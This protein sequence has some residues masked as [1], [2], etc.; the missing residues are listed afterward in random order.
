M[1]A[2]PA[3]SARTPAAKPA[4]PVPLAQA[5]LRCPSV[6][7]RDEGA[8]DLLQETLESLGAV[9][10]RLP[11]ETPGTARVD[12]LFARIGTGAPHFC[13]A[14]H[15]DVVP[16]GHPERW[17]VDP[18]AGAI[19]DG[20]LIA[21]GAADMKGAIA[22]FIAALGRYLEA[23][24]DA[25]AGSISLL[26]TGDEEGPA[27]NGTVKVLD[28]MAERGHVPDFCLVGEPT[29]PT[30]LGEAVK[31][32]RRGSLNAHIA[33]DGH[34][35][36]VAYPHL[37]EN[38]IPGLV[39]LLAAITAEPLDHGTDLFQPSNLEVTNLEVGN[40]APNVIPGRAEAHFNIRFNDL[41]TGES[42]E[43]WL[44]ERCDATGVAYALEATVSG[45]AF[46]TPPGPFSETVAEAVAHRLGRRPELTTTGGTSDARFIRS[47]CPVVEFGLV[48]ASMH[49]ANEAASLA[50]IEALTDIYH[51]VL[52]RVFTLPVSDH[53]TGAGQ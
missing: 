14:G 39:K 10:H 42:L 7:P 13:F 35:G 4:A 49:K 44:R 37:A 26:I 47:V 8:L 3:Q 41:H 15:T 31:I 29:N 19:E 52:D 38:P 45:E 43:R 27:T 34:Q 17:R 36:H 5:L 33:V 53:A 21:R 12:N 28:W 16:V 48:G 46:L 40:H 32:G 22:A 24:K 23:G 9:C 25:P 6:T 30:A 2:R 20:A 1:P 11:F 51:E 18:F 50:D